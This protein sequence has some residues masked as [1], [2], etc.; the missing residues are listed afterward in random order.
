MRGARTNS[1]VEGLSP[2]QREQLSIYIRSMRAGAFNM[3]H[4][5]LES[6]RGRFD[7]IESV[8]DSALS[9]LGSLPRRHVSPPFGTID[10]CNAARREWNQMSLLEYRAARDFYYENNPDADPQANPVAA[11]TRRPATAKELE[12]ARLDKAE[13]AAIGA[14]NAKHLL[15]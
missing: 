7:D 14:A 9:F 15:F 10:E 2:D 8:A 6:R 11:S 3:V 1:H 13:D 4:D 5:T 12:Y